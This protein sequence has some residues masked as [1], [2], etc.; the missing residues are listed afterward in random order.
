MDMSFSKHM[1]IIAAA[2]AGVLI[3]TGCGAKEHDAAFFA[4]DTYMQVKTYG[5]EDVSADIEE[6]VRALEDDLSVTDEQSDVYRLDHE[7]EFGVSDDAYELIGTSLDISRRTDGAL[8]MTV[9]PVL[10][11]WG[12]TSSTGYRVPAE[13]EISSLMEYVDYRR[14]D[15]SERTVRLPEGFMIDLGA[16]AMGYTGDRICALLAQKDITSAMID[17]GGNITALGTKPDGRPWKVA[18][19]CPYEEGYIC[20]LDICN[21][22][23]ITS[24][25][26]E[27]Y[28]EDED[29]N[30]YCHIIDP[31]SGHP[32]RNG[33]LSVTV[34]GENGTLCD[35]LSTAYYVM[36]AEKAVQ[37]WREYKDHEMIIIT[38]DNY[39]LVTPGLEDIITVTDDRYTLKVIDDED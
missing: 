19:R 3:M 38:D 8:D 13:D 9:Y 27:R 17:L 25:G 21:M 6:L 7:G 10:R 20:T 31:A 11:A 23:V 2:A 34:A 30:E 39:M 14:V 4:M 22:S 15:I 12:F 24:G 37:K 29:G 5:N 26:Y 35:G 28:F 16:T 1:R 36:G 32:V 33:I 18:V